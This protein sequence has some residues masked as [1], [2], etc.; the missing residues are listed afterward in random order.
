MFSF[1]GFV[2]LSGVFLGIVAI[3]AAEAAGLMYLVNRLNRKRGSKPASDPST[4]DIVNPPADFSLNKQVNRSQFLDYPLKIL[5]MLKSLT[6][7]DNFSKFEMF[8]NE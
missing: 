6:I 5:K 8:G 2:F 4:D 3:L 7:S 1:V